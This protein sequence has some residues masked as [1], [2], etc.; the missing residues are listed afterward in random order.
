MWVGEMAQPVMPL[1]HKR[2]DL[3]WVFRT[4]IKTRTGSDGSH[5]NAGEMEAGGL[6]GVP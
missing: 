4:Y 6:L 3:S 1:T 2:E 5:L